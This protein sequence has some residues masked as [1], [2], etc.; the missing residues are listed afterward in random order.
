MVGVLGVALIVAS[1]DAR[2]DPPAVDPHGAMV[3]ALNL[4]DCADCFRDQPSVAAMPVRAE[5]QRIF[6]NHENAPDRPGDFM[7]RTGQAAD[8]SPPWHPRSS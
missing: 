4:R 5:T 3:K 7:A 8:S 2:P 1:L 6:F